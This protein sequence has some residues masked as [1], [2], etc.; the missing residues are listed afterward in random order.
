MNTT[1]K[2]GCQHEPPVYQIRLQGQLDPRWRDWFAG[3]E[4][5]PEAG[6]Y[7]LLTGAMDQAALHGLLRKVSNL[8]LPLVSVIRLDLSLPV[9]E[10]G[11]PL[12]H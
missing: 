11:V 10:D 4:I 2:P 3:L 12:D 7:S 5:Q 6:G 1:G 8:G 9:G